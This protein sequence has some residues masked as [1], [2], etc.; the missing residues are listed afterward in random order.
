MYYNIILKRGEFTL[1]QFI[2]TDNTDS[3]D[4]LLSAIKSNIRVAKKHK[5]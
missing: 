2:D 3:N 5:K 1:K 4:E